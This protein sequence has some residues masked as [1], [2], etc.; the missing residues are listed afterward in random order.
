MPLQHKFGP[1]ERWLGTAQFPDFHLPGVRDAYNR[2]IHPQAYKRARGKN[3]SVAKSSELLALPAPNQVTPGVRGSFGYNATTGRH[4][5]DVTDPN[6]LAQTKATGDRN[7]RN[8]IIRSERLTQQAEAREVQK[9][10][11]EA[12]VAWAVNQPFPKRPLAGAARISKEKSYRNIFQ[13][14]TERE[15]NKVWDEAVKNR[16]DFGYEDVT[17]RRNIYTAPTPTEITIT[18]NFSSITDKNARYLWELV[19]PPKRSTAH[20]KRELPKKQTKPK[21][22]RNLRMIKLPRRQMVDC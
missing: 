12:L 7:R 19:N 18:P 6:K 15:Y 4:T 16:K 2:I 13:P 11:N 3:Q 22:K 10:K 8:E 17:P 9:A 14:V 5:T 21:T 20:I 1:G